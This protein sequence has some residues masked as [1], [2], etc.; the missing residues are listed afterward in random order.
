[1]EIK[2][3]ENVLKLNDEVAA[4]NRAVLAEQGVACIDLIGSPG[5]GKTALLE[6]T[7]QALQDEMR[8]GV[9]TGD[10][11]TTRDAERLQPFAQ[12]VMQINTGKACHLDA[13]QVR[14]GM[15]GLDLAD[16]D[17]LIVENVGNLICPVG[18]D[19]GQGAK[20]GMFSVTEGD[21]KPA[22]HPYVVLE[23]ALL[24][25]NK[26]DLLPY[27]PFDLERFRADVQAV[28][29]DVTLLE[30]ASVGNGAETKEMVGESGFREWLDWLRNLVAGKSALTSNASASTIT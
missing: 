10:L 27:V 26:L 15:Q 5:C 28:R 1:M 21:D 16:L 17:L 2:V 14:Q 24:I 4:L 3:V 9:L 19:L 11:A 13:N 6:R 8:V 12:Q 29:S 20:V 7:L 22:K 30:L 25:L 23:S 18:F